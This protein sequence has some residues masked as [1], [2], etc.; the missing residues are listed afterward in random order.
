ME[1]D[2]GAY[3]GRTTRQIHS[4]RPGWDLWKDGCPSGETAEQVGRRADTVLAELRSVPGNSAVFAHGHL[5]RVLGARWLG[6]KAESGA[7][8][9]LSPA[10]LS[11]LGYEHGRP[12]FLRWNDTGN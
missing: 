8:F 4:E 3:E 2:Y 5:L 9:A 6:L 11:I 12:V 7:L 1:W 10:G